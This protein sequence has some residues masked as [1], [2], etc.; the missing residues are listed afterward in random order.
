MKVRKAKQEDIRKLKDVAEKSYH[1]SYDGVLEEET[2]DKVLEDRYSKEGLKEIITSDES[3]LIVAEEDKSI[4]GFAYASWIN[5]DA[6]LESIYI[7][8]EYQSQ[9]IGTKMLNLIIRE[10]PKQ[11][12][13][14]GVGAIK[15]NEDAKY[16]YISNG[17]EEK[18]EV[19]E[20]FYGEKAKCKTFVKKLE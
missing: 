3:I 2:I 13:S 12:K 15:Q 20:D 6:E 10:L 8:P 5:A 17:F 16:F 7:L 9:G 18:E 1:D 14:V 4:V 19:M 11:V